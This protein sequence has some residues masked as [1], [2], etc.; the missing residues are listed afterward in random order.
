MRNLSLS[1]LLVLSGC[2]QADDSVCGSLPVNFPAGEVPKTV[3]DQVQVASACVERW[4]ARLARS[5]QDSAETVANAAVAG[6]AKAI[7][8]IDEIVPNAM[9]ASP[10]DHDYT[11]WRQRA[12]FVAVQTR[13]GRCYPDA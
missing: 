2:D 7:D 13:A 9:D 5:K 1:M 10:P 6:C 8:Y 12:L 4:A 3:N 11:E